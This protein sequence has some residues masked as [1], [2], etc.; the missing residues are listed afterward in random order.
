MTELRGSKTEKN[1]MAAFSGE[2]EARNKYTYYASQAKKDGYVQISKIF[3]ETA[4]NE[5]E[6]AKIWF[7]L[8][9]DGGIASTSDNL[10]D[11]IVEERK[12]WTNTYLKFAKEAREEGFNDIADTFEKVANI[13][14]N[15][16]KR[17]KKLLENIKEDSVFSKD[18]NVVW[19]CSNCGHTVVGKE[20][21][22][23]CPVC[24]HEQ[25]FFMLKA[26]NY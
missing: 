23:V 14:A 10:A 20:A 15:H 2:S 17:Y 26:E 1:L 7:K 13:E 24:D 9:H 18:V 12:E 11:S 5:K 22:K 19:Q 8:L 25:G 6:H 16:E 21:P 3:E 4:N